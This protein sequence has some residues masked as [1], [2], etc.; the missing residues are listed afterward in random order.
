MGV[1]NKEGENMEQLPGRYTIERVGQQEASDGD[2]VIVR[3]TIYL[4]CADDSV[5]LARACCFGNRLQV[6]GEYP[7]PYWGTHLTASQERTHSQCVVGQTWLEAETLA[8]EWAVAE[9]GKLHAAI[10]ARQRALRC[11]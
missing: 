10:R 3:A 5:G 8:E 7:W 11:A 6:A 4:P 2:G 9:L 1:N